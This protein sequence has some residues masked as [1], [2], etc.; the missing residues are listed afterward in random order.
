MTTDVVTLGASGVFAALLPHNA[1]PRAA[2][3]PANPER[4]T[5]LT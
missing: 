4:I 2:H 5:A 1:F 3:R